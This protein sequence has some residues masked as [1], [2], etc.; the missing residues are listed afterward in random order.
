MKPKDLRGKSV[1]DLLAA[2]KETDQALFNKRFQ[3]EVE[4]IT[5]PSEIRTLRR[6]VAR[7]KTVLREKGVRA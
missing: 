7:I 3:T 5:N 6:T 1:E 2:L 4:Q